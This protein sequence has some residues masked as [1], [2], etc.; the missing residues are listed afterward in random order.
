[1]S[2][3]KPLA[4]ASALLVLLSAATAVA[5]AAQTTETAVE[6]SASPTDWDEAQAT[7]AVVF[8]VGSDAESAGEQFDSI[9]VDYEP[10]A[11]PADVSNVGPES[12]RWVGIDRDGDDVGTRVDETATISEVDDA[13]DGQALRIQ[14]NGDLQ[15]SAGDEV[16]AVY[17]GVQN[18][19]D[20]GT[21]LESGVD[22]TLNDEGA[23][24]VASGGVTYEYNDAN[25]SVSDQETGGDTVVVDAVT[26][27]EPGFVVVLNE[28]GR[29]PDA[30]R[31][32][33]YLGAG[34][35]Q[36]VQVQLDPAVTDQEELHVQVHLD[37]DGD[38]RFEYAG[39]LVDRP[40]EDRDGTVMATASAQVTYANSA[41]TTTPTETATDTPTGTATDTSTDDGTTGDGTAT[42]T[43]DATTEDTATDET[44]GDDA[45]GDDASGDD[46]TEDEDGFG[47]ADVDGTDGDGETDGDGPGFG[48]A[49]AITVLLGAALVARRLS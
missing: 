23:S 14:T 22:V 48:A 46:A 27:S 36:D 3:R 18:P 45:S 26:L 44:T 32:A 7:H 33:T 38:R 4:V 5:P 29:N 12:V 47:T 16:V 34:S 10:G 49:T 40:F 2:G 15:L 37:T 20:Q 8:T 13:R 41:P 39:G 1:M 35:H 9:L 25:V 43:D 19:Q 30:V 28:S 17:G 11:E 6:V 31:G 42:A 24:D 21:T